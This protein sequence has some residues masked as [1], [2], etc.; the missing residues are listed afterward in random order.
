[1]YSPP[2]RQCSVPYGIDR[3]SL[4]PPTIGIQSAPTTAEGNW[5]MKHTL[6]VCGS[7]VL[8]FTFSAPGQ[9]TAQK[10]AGVP[11]YNVT[12]IERTTKAINYQYRSGPTLVDFRG[13]VLMPEAKGEATVES[14]RGRT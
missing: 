2:V 12:V 4:C 6:T 11:I 8:L 7:L 1:M 3:L 10:R 9:E 14:K 5:K 13:T